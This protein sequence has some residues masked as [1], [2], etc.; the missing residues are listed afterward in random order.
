M[1]IDAEA[2][3]ELFAAFGQVAV[4]RMFGAGGI[5]FDGVFFALI[6]EG[7]IYLKADDETSKRF[8]AEGC[9]RFSY[10]TRQRTV[11]TNL[12]RMPERLYDDPDEL[13][14]WARQAHA[15]ALRSKMKK[16]KPRAMAAAPSEP[17]RKRKVRRPAN[18]GRARIRGRSRK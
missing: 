13:A 15:V 1:T 8:V 9:K 10:T 16:K 5:Y 3:G 2:I 11:D 7:V 4:R 12:W 17:G 14:D 18:S 6:D